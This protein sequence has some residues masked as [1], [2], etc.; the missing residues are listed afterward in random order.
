M[1]F[2]LKNVDFKQ[3]KINKNI[4]KLKAYWKIKKIKNV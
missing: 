4:L 1:I 3:I 2:K